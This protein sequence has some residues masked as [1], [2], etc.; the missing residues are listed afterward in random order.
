MFKG[1]C[2]SENYENVVVLTTNWDRVVNKEEGNGR[3]AELKNVV[4]KE[5]VDGGAKFMRHKFGN[6]KTARDVLEHIFTLRPTDIAIQKEIR[7]EGKILGETSA[8]SVRRGEIE[9][10][11]ARHEE[12]M[13]NPREEMK[14]IQPENVAERQEPRKEWEGLNERLTRLEKERLALREGLDPAKQ[15]QGPF[16][17][18]QPKTEEESSNRQKSRNKFLGRFF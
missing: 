7:V 16:V 8:G 11:L 6:M 14:M 4:F 5:L 10:L 13:G 3:E 15:V 9:Q 2:G 12:E 18:K 17:P 1:L